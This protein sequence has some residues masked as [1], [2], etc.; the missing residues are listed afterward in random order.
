MRKE[1]DYYFEIEGNQSFGWKTKS[2]LETDTN[3]GRGMD[4]LDKL[5]LKVALLRGFKF[6][7]WRNQSENEMVLALPGEM[8]NPGWHLI[9]NPTNIPDNI[10]K[11]TYR[12]CGPFPDWPCDM[13]DAW[14]LVTDAEQA[15]VGFDLCN[16]E[17]TQ[18]EPGKGTTKTYSWVATFFD[19][20]GGPACRKFE[21]EA[22][23]APEAIASAYYD[24][25]S[26]G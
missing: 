4:N 10:F 9:E 25:Q 26:A 14:D 6:Y 21:A 16:C 12:Y 15:G 19:P 20:W 13:A 3:E 1:P 23:T 17:T 8:Q 2:Y 5:R 22:P 11:D 24:W 7:E 18:Y